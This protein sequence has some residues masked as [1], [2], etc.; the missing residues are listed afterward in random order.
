[1]IREA[2]RPLTDLA[3]G[4]VTVTLHKGRV[5][6]DSIKDEPHSLYSEANASMEAIGEFD[7]ADSEG[8]LRVLQVSAKALAAAGQIKPPQSRWGGVGLSGETHATAFRTRRR[9]ARRPLRNAAKRNTS[10]R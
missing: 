8:F 1:M 5:I 7:H 9:S 10:L 6:F 4:T 2:L 3:T